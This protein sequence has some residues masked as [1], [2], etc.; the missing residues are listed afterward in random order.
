MLFYEIKVN[1]QRQTGEDNPGNVKETYLVEGLTPADVEKRLLEHIKPFIFGD[2]EMP[3]CTKKQYFEMVTSP[4]ADK[5]YK[6]RVELITIEDS[7][8]ETRKTVSL[9]VQAT[10]AAHAMKNLTQAVNGYDC[11]IVSIARTPIMEVIRAVD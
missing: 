10:T 11:E 2:F 9:L 5:W 1:Y 6:G 7:G 3:S 4:E 8:K